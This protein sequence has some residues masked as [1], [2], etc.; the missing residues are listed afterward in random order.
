[1]D[2]ENRRERSPKE[3]GNW[4]VSVDQSIKSRRQGMLTQ[5]DLTDI[6]W[7][8]GYI[9][10]RRWVAHS[11]GIKRPLYQVMFEDLEPTESEGNKWTGK[12]EPFIRVIEERK[13]EEGIYAKMRNY[14]LERYRN[15]KQF[16]LVKYN[17][18]ISSNLT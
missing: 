6:W 4:K 18:V 16:V 2:W 7:D 12:I 8:P 17:R 3:D 15:W 14:K 10:V 5:E 11:P 1:M 13:P 9:R